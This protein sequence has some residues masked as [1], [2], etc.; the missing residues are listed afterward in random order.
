VTMI[1]LVLVVA[2]GA[3]L[4]CALYMRWHMRRG[5]GAQAGGCCGHGQQSVEELRARQAAVATELA[6]RE[7]A[8]RHEVLS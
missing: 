7:G 3:A 5:R 2:V 6:G 4:A 1:V 8:E